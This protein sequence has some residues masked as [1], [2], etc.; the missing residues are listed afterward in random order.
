MQDTEN[1][2]EVEEIITAFIRCTNT[3]DLQYTNA[4]ADIMNID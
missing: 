2:A 4:D 1:M 3:H